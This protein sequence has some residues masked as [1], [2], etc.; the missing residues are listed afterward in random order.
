MAETTKSAQE[1]IRAA[2]SPISTEQPVTGVRASGA[3]AAAGQAR[4][5]SAPRE[6][7]PTSGLSGAW[8]QAMT[9]SRANPGKA[10]LIVFGVGVGLGLLMANGFTTRS[11]TRRIVPPVMNAL[12]EIA[13]ELFR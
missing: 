4:E 11:R 1:A 7:A 10:T 6:P 5:R 12:S 8:E 3:A 13:S 9:Y 2:S